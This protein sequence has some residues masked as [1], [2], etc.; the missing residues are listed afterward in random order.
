MNICGIFSSAT[1]ASMCAPDTPKMLWPGGH[2]LGGLLTFVGFM[3]RCANQGLTRAPPPSPLQ[4]TTPEHHERTSLLGRRGTAG[5][6]V[7]V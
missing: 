3:L 1:V 4:P 2:L 6:G 5:S 7:S